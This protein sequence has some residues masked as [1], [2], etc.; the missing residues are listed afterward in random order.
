MVAACAAVVLAA[1]PVA[2][3]Q[4]VEPLV[5]DRPDFTESSVTVAPG[6]F[7]FE[8]GYT[9]SQKGEEDEHDFG[10][11]LV[12]L[13]IL[14]WLEGRFAFNSF[15]LLRQPGEDGDGINDFT[16][17]M[18]AR[19]LSPDDGA[20]RA[21]PHVA[22]LL[23][24]ELPIGGDDI[25]TDVVVPGV[26]LAAAWKLGRRASLSSNVGWARPS[27]D[28]GRY[29]VGLASLALGYSLSEPLGAFVEWYGL[30]PGERD[31]GSEHYVNGGLAL[32]LSPNAQVD[33]RIGAGLQDPDPNWFTGAGFSFRL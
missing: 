9:F 32:L 21:V 23:G 11:L 24:A 7:Q 3:A 2:R 13:G 1:P 10:E 31:G 27:D 28:Q 6:R 26:K 15:V 4:A 22:L 20:S 17:A 19:L 29:G 14:P 16:V 8:L 18:K 33:W 25:G 5:T 30:F 12:R